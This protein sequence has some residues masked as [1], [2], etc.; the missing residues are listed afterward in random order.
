VND[1]ACGG[2]LVMAEYLSHPLVRT[3]LNVEKTEFFSVDNAEGGFDYTPSERDLTSF[4][5][6]MNGKLRILVYNGGM[7][8]E[9]LIF[10]IY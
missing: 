7:Y 5:K 1:Y 2:D 3:A 8:S 6:A 9:R 4:Y 10:I